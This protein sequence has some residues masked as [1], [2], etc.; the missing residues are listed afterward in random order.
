[1]MSELEEKKME[2]PCFEK[3]SKQQYQ[4]EKSTSSGLTVNLH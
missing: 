2:I 1:L 4:I 3:E